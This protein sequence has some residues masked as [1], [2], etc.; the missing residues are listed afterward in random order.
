MKRTL[1]RELKEL[2]IVEM[3]AFSFISIH[4]GLPSLVLGNEL[5]V[6]RQAWERKMHQLVL[7]A[8]WFDWIEGSKCRYI[9]LE[10]SRKI[11]VCLVPRSLFKYLQTQ[12]RLTGNK[13]KL[14]QL[15]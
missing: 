8:V 14:I 7:K 4:T 9:D 10:Q 2:E 6:G 11:P 1:E 3:E 12:A 5:W 15:L 13:R